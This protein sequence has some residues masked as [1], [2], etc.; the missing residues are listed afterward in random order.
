MF[1]CTKCPQMYILEEIPTYYR[2]PSSK[3]WTT[4][5]WFSRHTWSSSNTVL[6]W[7]SAISEMQDTTCVQHGAVCLSSTNDSH[8]W[9]LIYF[10]F[11]KYL[12]HGFVSQFLKRKKILRLIIR[13]NE[14]NK[15]VRRNPFC[16]D[17]NTPS[18][19][20]YLLWASCFWGTGNRIF[21]KKVFK[22]DKFKLEFVLL[23]DA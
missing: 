17:G 20:A 6:L 21:F 8:Y 11:N 22:Q 13:H 12:G 5:V 14:R 15:A 3:V 1:L 7:W 19:A 18:E 2:G 4:F 16:T 9:K 10:N 23:K